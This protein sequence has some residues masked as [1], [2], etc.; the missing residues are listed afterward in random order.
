MDYMSTKKSFRLNAPKKTTFW[1]SSALGA[2]GIVLG[3]VSLFVSS[4]FLAVAV[5]VLLGAGWL[6]VSL[7]C[8][9]KGL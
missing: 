4:A 2:L 6:L 7:G 1:I 5:P 8:F 9:V 3:I